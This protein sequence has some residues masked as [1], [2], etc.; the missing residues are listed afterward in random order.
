MIELDGRQT[1][2]LAILTLFLGKYLNS[3]MLFLRTWNIPEPVVGGVMISLISAAIYYLNGSEVSFNL[4]SRDGLLIVFFTT[5]GLNSRLSTLLAGG[6]PL[7]ILLVAAIVYLIIQNATGVGI[8]ILAGLPESIGILGGSVSLSGGHGTA[9]AWGDEFQSTYGIESAK[10]MGIACA[11]FGLILG[12]IIGGPVGNFLIS[13]HQLKPAHPDDDHL[14][15]L[16]LEKKIEQKRDFEKVSV[17]GVLSCL[18]VIAVAAGL[19]SAIGELL[20]NYLNFQLPD[21]VLCLFAG[22]LLTNLIGPRFKTLKWP[23]ETASLALVSDLSLGLFLAMSLMSLQIQSLVELA[24]P[25]MLLLFAQVIVM[26]L[27]AIFVIFRLMGKNYDAAVMAAG[28]CGLGLGATPTAIA[29]MSAITKKSGPS[30]QAF[31]LL[32]LVGAFFIDI[33][34]A[35]VIKGFL[36]WFG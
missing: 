15:G 23:S 33:A 19:G 25:I 31:L 29:N 35:F 30:P 21:F 17:D 6:K 34:N 10:E 28:Y 5:I 13:R 1:L 27:W 7:L 32:P 36:S 24:G 16:P 11:T 8:A 12:G 4:D 3:K 14:V 20:D 18:L 9:I 2:I 26:I 22:I